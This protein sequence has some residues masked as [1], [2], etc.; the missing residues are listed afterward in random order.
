M[1]AMPAQVPLSLRAWP[2]A[3]AKTKALPLLIS[4]INIERGN[5]RD[6]TEEALAQELKDAEREVTVLDSAADSD[7]GEDD[8]GPEEVA[9]GAE[10][11][12]EL[13]T[14]RDEMLRQIEYGLPAPD[15]TTEANDTT[16]KP[17]WRL[18]SPSTLSLYSCRK[19]LLCR[20]VSRCRP[21]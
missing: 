8:D 3:D 7:G 17:T 5:F 10:R 13:A 15:S 14:G 12:K 9:D 4:R 20:L 18:F 16:V 19:T 6:V 21:S 2:S 11:L 1:T